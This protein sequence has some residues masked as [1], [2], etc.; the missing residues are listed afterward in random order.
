MIPVR[1]PANSVPHVIGG[2]RTLGRDHPLYRQPC[3][4]DD[5]PLGSPYVLVYVG[6]HPS[7]RQPAGFET[8]AAV[9]VHAAC[10]GLDLIT[11]AKES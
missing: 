3:P 2:P 9:A 7:E 6:T 4:V 10:A 1:V 8:G 11:V 5:R